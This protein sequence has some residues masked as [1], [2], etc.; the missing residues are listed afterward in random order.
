[1]RRGAIPLLIAATVLLAIAPMSASALTQQRA[2]SAKMGSTGSNG[3]ITLR[4]YTN[5]VGLISYSLK[6]LRASTTYGVL[7]RNGTCSS[8]G[9]VAVTLNSVHTAGNGTVSHADNILPWAI[10]RIWPAARKSSF[11]VQIVSRVPSGSTTR[12]GAFSFVH[13]TRVTVP[14]LGIDLPIVRG[15]SGYPY[16]RVAMYFVATSQPREPGITFIF[17]HA[18]TGMFLPLLTRWKIHSG[19]SLLGRTVKVWT[20]NSYVNYYRIVKV[21]KT[22]NPMAGV[23]SLTSERL[24]LQTSTGPNTRYPKL[25]VE[26]V[27]YK[28]IKSTYASAHP[29]PHPVKC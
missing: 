12:C 5:G 3:T 28:T 18:R 29:T 24:W 27:R 23:T 1:M 16:C 4:A 22:S 25:I 17:A 14:G 21:R 10:E 6:G 13:A 20:S 7:I 11:V 19:A 26:A 8:L 15:P 9:S 2:W